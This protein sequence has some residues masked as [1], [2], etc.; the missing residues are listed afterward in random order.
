MTKKDNIPYRNYSYGYLQES[1][2]I[3]LLFWSYVVVD[4]H[5]KKLTELS[6]LSDCGKVKLLEQ[7]WMYVEVQSNNSRTFLHCHQKINLV[8]IKFSLKGTSNYIYNQSKNS[9]NS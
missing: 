4:H 5:H 1:Q 7:W 2:E 6:S 3:L 8:F 9:S